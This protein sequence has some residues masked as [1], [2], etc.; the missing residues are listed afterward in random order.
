[1]PMME[2]IPL[3]TSSATPTRQ[4]AMSCYALRFPDGPIWLVDC[5]EG[6]QFRLL[7]SDLRPPRIERILIT[8]LHG[9]HVLGLPG[10]LLCLGLHG[11]QETVHLLGPSGLR[12]LI[13]GCLRHTGSHLPFPLEIHELA[14][15]GEA[16]AT[17]RG[18][19]TVFPILHTLPSFAYRLVLPPRRGQ[20]DMAVVAALGL[21][22]GPL[23]GRLARGEDAPAP[24]GRLIRAGTVLGPPRLGPR[25]LLCGDTCD[26]S[27]IPADDEGLDLLLHEA[28]YGDDRRDKARFWGHSCA[29]EAG[30]TAA[31]LKAR[32]LLLSHFS[33]RYHEGEGPGGIEELRQQAASRCPACRVLIARDFQ[34]LAWDG[35][36]FHEKP[37]AP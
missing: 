26:T 14:P 29:G 12:E 33:A 11:R 28:T 31:R 16:F 24:D 25:L 36:A 20:L 30:G 18:E 4:R 8:H 1:M 7:T 9:D 2:L 19:V 10:L 21:E 5:A 23:L 13:A 22:P 32:L 27:S 15:G 34:A 17:D 6:S 35:R 3:G 37:C